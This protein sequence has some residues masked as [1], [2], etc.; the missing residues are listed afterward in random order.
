MSAGSDG[1]GALRL[2]LWRGGGAGNEPAKRAAVYAAV[3]GDGAGGDGA[4]RGGEV[5][6]VK[7]AVRCDCPYGA[8]VELGTSR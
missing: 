8:A 1:G 4:A 2:P 5:R 6:G 7:A 3:G